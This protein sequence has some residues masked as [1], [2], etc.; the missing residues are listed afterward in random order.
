MHIFLTIPYSA[1]RVYPIFTT[2]QGFP[3]MKYSIDD[4]I[5]AKQKARKQ[6]NDLQSI[7]RKTAKQ[8]TELKTAIHNLSEV[9]KIVLN[10]NCWSLDEI[11]AD[12]ET[13]AYLQAKKRYYAIKKRLDFING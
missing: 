1:F 11:I 4:L 5:I 2:P 13:D 3:I 6:I 9:Y 10:G 12:D 8:K 7:K